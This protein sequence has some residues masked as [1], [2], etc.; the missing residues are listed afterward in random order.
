MVRLICPHCGCPFLRVIPPGEE[1]EVVCPR[2]LRA[3]VADDA[4]LVDPED[5]G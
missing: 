1:E 3:F 4:D 5:G 2:C